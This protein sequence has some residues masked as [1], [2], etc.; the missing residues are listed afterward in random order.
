MLKLRY[1]LTGTTQRAH[2]HTRS[3]T[4][5]HTHRNQRQA[6]Q[7]KTTKEE[8]EEEEKGE[9]IRNHCVHS[10]W[11]PTDDDSGLLLSQLLFLPT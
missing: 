2:K 7:I 3:H 10:R 4:H 8:E 11:K 6:E 5:T 9:V 1:Q